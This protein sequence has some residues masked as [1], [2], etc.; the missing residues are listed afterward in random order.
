[1]RTYATVF[2]WLLPISIRM[3]SFDFRFRTKELYALTMMPFFCQK[4]TISRCWQEGWSCTHVNS[5]NIH[6]L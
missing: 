1:M 2:P 5:T 6:G 4:S 3:G